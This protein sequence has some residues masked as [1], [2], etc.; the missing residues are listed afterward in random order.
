VC[1]ASAS[2]VEMTLLRTKRNDR[3]CP[4]WQEFR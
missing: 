4:V 2:T 1:R 3:Y